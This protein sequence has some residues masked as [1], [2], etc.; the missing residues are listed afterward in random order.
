MQTAVQNKMRP[1]IQPQMQHPNICKPWPNKNKHQR[2]T[3]L[4]STK[5]PNC[6]RRT[7]KVES[8]NNKQ[9]TTKKEANNNHPPRNDAVPIAIAETQTFKLQQHEQASKNNDNMQIRNQW[10]AKS[11]H[12]PPNQQCRW[13]IKI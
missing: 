10:H 13:S 2:R 11:K 8:S 1:K 7:D 6:S 3:Q 9:H 5:R 4:R 12:G